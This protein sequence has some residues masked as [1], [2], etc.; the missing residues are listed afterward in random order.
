MKNLEQKFP[1]ITRGYSTIKFL[2]ASK[3]IRRPITARESLSHLKNFDFYPCLSQNVA[4]RDASRRKVML[5]M[6][7]DQV[8][9]NLA[10][11]Q[12]KNL[13]NVQNAPE[14]NGL[15]KQNTLYKS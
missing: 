5:Q 3:P 12:P 1:A 15:A 13:Q 6:P 4:K 9:A 2:T 7:F 10:N 11:I 8:Y 14:V